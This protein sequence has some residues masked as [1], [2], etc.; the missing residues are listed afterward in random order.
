V[1]PTDL[2]VVQIMRFD[3]RNGDARVGLPHKEDLTE[4]GAPVISR[5]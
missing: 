1:T 3:P 5:S 2:K 4:E